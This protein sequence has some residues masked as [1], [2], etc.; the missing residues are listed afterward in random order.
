[1]LS[2]H[3]VLSQKECQTLTPNYTRAKVIIVRYQGCKTIVPCVTWSSRFDPFNIELV[4]S[5]LSNIKQQD[6]HK[7]S[8]TEWLDRSDKLP[9]AKF[10]NSFYQRVFCK[11]F[12]G[13]W[14][15]WL[16][17]IRLTARYTNLASAKHKRKVGIS[18]KTGSRK[19][20]KQWESEPQ[21]GFAINSISNLPC[22]LHYNVVI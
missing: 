4:V 20:T 9:K 11:S 21:R 18:Q 3:I 12:G 17:S 5:S 14:F 10:K 15:L 1:M 7:E 13:R 22:P 19:Y 6:R 16:Q 2:H 8:Q